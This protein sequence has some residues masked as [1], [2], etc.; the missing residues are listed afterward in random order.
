MKKSWRLTEKILA[1]EKTLETRW[2]KNKYPPWNN[3]KKG[4]I[5]YFKDSGEPV[6]IKAEVTKFLRFDNL[7]NKKSNNI[8]EKYGNLD[9]GNKELSLEI[10][11]YINNKNYCIL[12]FFD[13][14]MKIKPFSIDKKGFGLMSSWICVDNVERLKKR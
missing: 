1:G 4:D 12:I 2:Y 10:K 6:T 11:N 9:T 14:V 13:K 3:I 8:M 5:I 7:D